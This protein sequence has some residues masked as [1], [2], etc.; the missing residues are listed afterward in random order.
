MEVLDIIESFSKNTFGPDKI[1]PKVV[2][3]GAPALS[4]TLSE[5]INKFFA[6]A[7]DLTFVQ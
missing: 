1:P 3:L 5:L 2:K 4:N 6:I 7:N